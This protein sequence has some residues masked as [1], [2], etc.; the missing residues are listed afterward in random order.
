[1]WVYEG[2][3]AVL[4]TLLACTASNP[5]APAPQVAMAHVL[6]GV[7][8]VLLA[9]WRIHMWRRACADENDEHAQRWAGRGTGAAGRA[10]RRGDSHHL[11]AAARPNRGVR[12]RHPYPRA[13]CVPSS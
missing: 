6:M 9:S 11:C 5:H 13:V 8:M 12:C 2:E 3:A 10:G 4:V 1:M 7:G